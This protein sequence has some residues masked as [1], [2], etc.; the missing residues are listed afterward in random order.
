MFIEFWKSLTSDAIILDMIAGIKIPFVSRPI[1]YHVP[2]EIKC[3]YQ[4][5]IASDR[6][7]VDY[8]KKRY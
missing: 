1:Q 6:E 8:L 5:K 7:I 2:Q 4:E 3:S